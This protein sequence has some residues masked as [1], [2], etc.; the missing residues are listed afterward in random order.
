M[1]E[2]KLPKIIILGLEKLDHDELMEVFYNLLV[3]SPGDILKYDETPEHKIEKLNHLLKF[4]EEREQYEK[5]TKIK[6]L[7]TTINLNMNE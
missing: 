6:E 7:Q 4:F 3:S 2:N 5:C 1:E